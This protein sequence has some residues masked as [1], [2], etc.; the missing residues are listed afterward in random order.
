M[1][2][3]SKRPCRHGSFDPGLWAVMS[4]SARLAG[5]SLARA[6][7]QRPLLQCTSPLVRLQLLAK[8]D[9]HWA[10]ESRQEGKIPETGRFP[11]ETYSVCLGRIDCSHRFEKKTDN[12][13]GTAGS[14]SDSTATGRKPYTMIIDWPM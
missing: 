11:L 1:F 10:A 13:P 4:L 5:Q 8:I 3:V 7:A 2:S 12:S 6:V 9:D 14:W